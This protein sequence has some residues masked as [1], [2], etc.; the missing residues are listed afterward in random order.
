MSFLSQLAENSA[1]VLAF[2]SE[3]FEGA[4]AVNHDRPDRAP[5]HMTTG[6]VSITLWATRFDHALI[7]DR[8]LQCNSL[9]AFAWLKELAENQDLP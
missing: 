7:G 2:A 6:L 1:A 8:I 4:V 3:A 9:E 5:F